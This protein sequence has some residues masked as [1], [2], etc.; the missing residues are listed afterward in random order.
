M[1]YQIY[2]SGYSLTIQPQTYYHNCSVFEGTKSECERRLELISS[3]PH[4]LGNTVDGDLITSLRILEL[5]DSYIVIYYG[6]KS[7]SPILGSETL[8]QS[9]VE[10]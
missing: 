9:V 1:K 8:F 5:V 4:Q 3:L 6:H 2:Q 10:K 7:K